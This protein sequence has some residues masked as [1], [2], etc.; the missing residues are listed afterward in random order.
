M[1]TNHLTE[2][3]GLPVVNYLNLPGEEVREWSGEPDLDPGTLADPGA[4]AWGLSHYYDEMGDPRS[5]RRYLTGFVESV[6]DPAAVTAVVIGSL[7][8]AFEVESSD[9]VRDLLVELAPRLPGLRSLFYADLVVE[10]CEASWIRHGN[11]SPLVAAFPGLTGFA[12]RGTSHLSMEALEHDG[13]RGLT[14]QGGGLPRKLARQVVGARLPSLEHLELWLGVED[15]G[16]DTAPEDLGPVLSGEAFPK[17]RTLGLRNTE[18]LRS[19]FP[20]LAEA[21]VLSSLEVLDLSLGDLSDEG[22][23]ALIDLAPAFRGLKRLDLHHHYLSE[24]MCERVR[25]ALP[26]VEVDLSDVR[27][28]EI[29]GDEDDEDR[30]VY[31]YTAVAE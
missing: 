15:Y 25:A 30:E 11:L 27:E 8:E 13:L 19:W 9:E 5:A 12:V 14:L 1:F 22:A 4:V 18:N 24:D 21:P 29:D 20:V 3:A 10:E 2:F 17:L 23:R 6:S 31:Y 26:G 16:G 28:P 7:V